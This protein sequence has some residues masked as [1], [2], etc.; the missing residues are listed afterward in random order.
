M[1]ACSQVS[2]VT[3]L[4]YDYAV[5]MEHVTNCSSQWCFANSRYLYTTSFSISLLWALPYPLKVGVCTHNH[6]S[7]KALGYITP[8]NIQI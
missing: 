1:I 2:N 6:V 5:N 8:G 3:V 4:T 7:E